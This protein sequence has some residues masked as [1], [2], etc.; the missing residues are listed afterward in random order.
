MATLA[1]PFDINSF[2]EQENSKDL[3]RFTTAGSVDDGKSTLIGR[4]LFDSRN[5]YEDQ[6]RAVTRA[7]LNRGA[8]QPD[9]SLLTDGLRAEREQGI[10]IDVAYR[11]FSTA[12]RKFILADTPGH[13]QY[14][15]NMVTGASSAQLAIILVDARKGIQPQSR[16]HAYVAALLGIRYFVVAINKMDLVDYD[17]QVFLAIKADFQKVLDELKIQDA[18]FVPLSALA[19][20]NVVGSSV[21][22][23]WF[24]GPSLLEYLETVQT[25]DPRSEQPFRLPV[26]RVIRPH[27]DYRGYAGRVSSGTIRAG[28]E[29]LV[30]PSGRKTHV[31][32]VIS[33]GGGLP[34]AWPSMSVSLTLEDELDISRGDL[35]C[36]AERQ[37]PAISSRFTATLVWFNE[38]P[39]QPEKTY[40]LKHTTRTLRAQVKALRNRLNINTFER[41]PAGTL[42]LNEIGVAEI[43]ASS[44]IYFDPY[45]QNPVTGSLLLIDPATNATV[46]AGMILDEI[47]PRAQ[48]AHQSFEALQKR[49]VSA[50]DRLR[51]Y[52]HSGAAVDLGRRF[53]VAHRLE[54]IL[55][56]QG[57][58]VVVVRDANMQAVQSLVDSGFL[59]LGVGIPDVEG[60]LHPDIQSEED[61]Q[62]V[63]AVY[64]LLVWSGVIRTLNKE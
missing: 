59:V 34:A 54:R 4:L 6:V 29:V 36:S 25:E 24:Y 2:I 62:S 14:T 43:E 53:E 44:P 17:E 32:E 20:D 35:I 10:T 64:D 30:L 3:L 21:N 51:R 33:Y 9:L 28:D 55:F 50:E 5:V 48:Q 13:E 19:G 46:A 60:A 23:P 11:Y 61:D 39:L 37:P 40:L 38:Q 45:Q 16:R 31:S 41:E 52:G 12:R 15:R 63:Q 7:S 56:D 18:W 8:S 47:N 57:A 26:Q 27:Q 42:H 49:P 1:A 58:A 22:M